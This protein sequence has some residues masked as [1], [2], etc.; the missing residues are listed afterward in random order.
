MKCFCLL[1]SIWGRYFRNAELEKI[2]ESDLTRL[3]PEHGSFFQSFVCQAMLRRILLVWALIYPQYGY[4]QGPSIAH[5]WSDYFYLLVY[6][7]FV[8]VSSFIDGYLDSLNMCF[9]CIV[10]P[11][12]VDRVLLLT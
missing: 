5:T 1:D 7:I 9:P 11:F 8:V 10:F 2:I 6:G 3:Y 12:V 4:R